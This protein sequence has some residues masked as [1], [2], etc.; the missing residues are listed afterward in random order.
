MEGVKPLAKGRGIKMSK[1]IFLLP[2]LIVFRFLKTFLWITLMGKFFV[3]LIHMKFPKWFYQ[4]Q[5]TSWGRG[6][7]GRQTADRMREATSPRRRSR[8]QVRG[9]MEAN[10]RSSTP[11][12]ALT[13]VPS[14]KEGLIN[15]LIPKWFFVLSAQSSSAR[16]GLSQRPAS[17]TRIRGHGKRIKSALKTSAA[18]TVIS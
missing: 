7:A 10:L 6:A 12:S 3:E 5:Q 8:T 9:A 18:I 14:G 4:V 1:L 17:R 2:Q 16:I 11:L 15:V 13:T